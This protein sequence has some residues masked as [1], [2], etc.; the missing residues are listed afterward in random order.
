MMPQSALGGL[1][2]PILFEAESNHSHRRAHQV[3]VAWLVSLV[4]I[5][6]VICVLLWWSGAWLARLLLDVR[7]LDSPGPLMLWIGIGHTL[8]GAAQVMENRLFSF[9]DTRAALVPTVASAV[10]NLAAT[11]LLI[12]PF[13]ILGAAIGTTLAY[14]VQC[15]LTVRALYR[16]RGTAARAG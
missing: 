10:T 1:L 2:R 13:G 3:F 7:Y 5:D 16:H 8:F 6:A 9:G 4:A 11:W 15:L 14:A 12:P